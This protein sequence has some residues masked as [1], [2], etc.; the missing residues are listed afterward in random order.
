MAATNNLTWWQ[1]NSDGPLPVPL[2]PSIDLSNASIVRWW[3]AKKVTSIG[4]DIFVMKAYPDN[5]LALSLSGGVWSVLID[6]LPEDTED[7]PAGSYYHECEL[8]DTQDRVTTLFRGKIRINKVLIP[9]SLD[10]P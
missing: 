6:F 7:V 5:G 2:D 4:S 1:G 10:L 8:V 9:A 3:M